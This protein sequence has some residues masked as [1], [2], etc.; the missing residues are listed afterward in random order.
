MDKGSRDRQQPASG[1]LHDQDNTGSGENEKL[2]G[3]REQSLNDG[4]TPDEP[5]LD[6]E[7]MEE[8]DLEDDDLDNIEWDSV[9]E[10]QGAGRS[11]GE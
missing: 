11:E 5:I 8:N 4:T 3:I 7:D 9:K 2:S 10:D 6:E 1:R